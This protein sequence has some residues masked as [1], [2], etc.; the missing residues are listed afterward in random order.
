MIVDEGS[1]FIKIPI[2]VYI[3]L[4][5][6]IWSVLFQVIKKCLITIL[7][8]SISI[9]YDTKREDTEKTR[10]TRIHDEEQCS[11]RR[12]QRVHGI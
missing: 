9:R 6:F 11:H 2:L 10:C 4:C 5:L 8:L 7:I 12:P 3:L 1:D